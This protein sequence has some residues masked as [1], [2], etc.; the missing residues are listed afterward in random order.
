M[1]PAA[2]L[3]DIFG[4][5][6]N[7]GDG[8]AHVAQ[9]PPAV[10]ACELAGKAGRLAAASEGDRKQMLRRRHAERSEASMHPTPRLPDIFGQANERRQHDARV[11]QPPSAVR[12]CELDGKA[13]DWQ[14]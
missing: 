4:E 9:P 12:I 2:R 8:D 7:A 10:W 11:A 1:H 14:Q 3:P 13:G 5:R 6:M